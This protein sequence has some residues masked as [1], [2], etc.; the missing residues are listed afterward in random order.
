M[1]D[2]HNPFI[3]RQFL[4]SVWALDFA[5]FKDTPAERELFDRLVRWSRRAD[6][7]E[8]SAQSAFLEEFFRKTWGYVQ[9]GQAGGEEAFSLIP[10]F[11]LRDHADG[12]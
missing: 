1:Q 7:R 10:D 4:R 3:T 8:R 12:G 6:L 9:S 5:A 11:G 2:F